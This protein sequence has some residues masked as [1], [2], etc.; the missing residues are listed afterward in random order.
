MSN[1][2][3]TTELAWAETVSS[4]EAAALLG[5]ARQNA[6][7]YRA[8]LGAV[9][10]VRPNCSRLEWRFPISRVRALAEARRLQH[11][12]SEAARAI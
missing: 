4:R 9:L 6:A 7:R 11:I 8:Q 1:Q 3:D 12:T 5:V 10:M 2:L